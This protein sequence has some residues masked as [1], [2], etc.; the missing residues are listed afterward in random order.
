MEEECDLGELYN[1]S[2]PNNVDVACTKD[3]KITDKNLWKCEWIEVK[4]GAGI[5]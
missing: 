1:T 3:C 4:D 5:T 2:D